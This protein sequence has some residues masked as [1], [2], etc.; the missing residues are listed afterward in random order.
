MPSR[1]SRSRECGW[2]EIPRWWEILGTVAPRPLRGPLRRH[3]R[4]T[5]DAPTRLTIGALYEERATCV[6][7]SRRQRAVPPC[8]VVEIDGA[9]RTHLTSRRASCRAI[10]HLAMT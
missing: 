9:A 1:A 2:G 8:D 5:E 3:S 6:C 10:R 7:T 4:P